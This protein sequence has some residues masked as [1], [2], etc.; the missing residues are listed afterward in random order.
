[1]GNL[2][3]RYR[4]WHKEREQMYEV[5][6][7]EWMRDG[8]VF[9]VVVRQ[10]SGKHG[11]FGRDIELMQ[12]TGLRDKNGVLIYEGDKLYHQRIESFCQCPDDEMFAVVTWHEK[13]ISFIGDLR[14]ACHNISPY[15]FDECEITGCIHTTPPELLGGD[16]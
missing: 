15:I 13:N 6:E 16:A 11:Y 12:C 1:M 14:T 2:R 3:H 4:A 9:R 5:T 8:T 7:I 10:E